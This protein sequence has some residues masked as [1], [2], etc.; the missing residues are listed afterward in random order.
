MGFQ[1]SNTSGNVR[2]WS[3]ATFSIAAERVRNEVDKILLKLLIPKYLFQTIW[4]LTDTGRVGQ[5]S[6]GPGEWNTSKQA[7]LPAYYGEE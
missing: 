2:A 6:E 7:S 3:K 1:G 5:G 4:T